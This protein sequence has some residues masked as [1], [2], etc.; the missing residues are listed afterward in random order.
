MKVQPINRTSADFTNT[1][2]ERTVLR[3]LTS[4]EKGN[5]KC[6][7]TSNIN[8]QEID[9]IVKKLKQ[10]G[11]SAYSVPGSLIIQK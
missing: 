10:Q 9:N 3:S 5:R 8:Q 2:F 1:G 11:V 6:F 4:I 7:S